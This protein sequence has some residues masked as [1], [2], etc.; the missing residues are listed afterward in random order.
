MVH[1][2][3]PKKAKRGNFFFFFFL[4]KQDFIDA[5]RLQIKLIQAAGSEKRSYAR[6]GYE[7]AAR[8]CE[9]TA[10]NNEAVGGA[11][12]DNERMAGS[13][14]RQTCLVFDLHVEGPGS[15]GETY[16]VVLDR[17]PHLEPAKETKKK[18]KRNWGG[19]VLS[20]T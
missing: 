19:L 16:P 6:V 2:F 15:F 18:V 8:S 1:P 17:P 11:G 10:M 5:S 9:R 14:P 20:L 7:G 4:F 12:D 13:S 3:F